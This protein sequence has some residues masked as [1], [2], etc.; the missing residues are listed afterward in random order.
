MSFIFWAV[1][2]VAC[3][4][5]AQVALK[6][7]ADDTLHRWQAW[8]SP[9]ILGG[10]LLYGISFA[11]TVRVYAH[12]PLGVISPAMAGGIFMLISLAAVLLFGETLTPGKVVG[13]G[14][15][16]LGILLLARSA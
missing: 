16:V 13:M 3:N 6:F 7:G 1:V 5:G 12:F 8:F 4:A 11:L 2:A 9:P 14:C 10:L 15:I